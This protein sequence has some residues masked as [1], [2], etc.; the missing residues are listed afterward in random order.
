MALSNKAKGWTSVVV[1]V[2]AGAWGFHEWV[3]KSHLP[4]HLM[5]RAEAQTLQHEV[6]AAVDTAKVAAET[7]T[8][9]SRR[10]FDYI[11]RQ[12]LKEERADLERLKG[13]LQETL[14]WESQN[15]ENALSRSRKADLNAR[16]RET[17]ERIR[18]MVTPDAGGC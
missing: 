18:C 2:L 5:T 3:G 6:K 16:I 14:L 10:L 15:G 17:E 13:E 1:A 9:T 12:E 8:E 7:A 4:V 11:E